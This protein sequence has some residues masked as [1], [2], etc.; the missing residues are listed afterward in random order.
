MGFMSLYH[1][2]TGRVMHAVVWN[3]FQARQLHFPSLPQLC[4]C[5]YRS[6]QVVDWLM[7]IL[8]IMSKRA[9][10]HSPGAKKEPDG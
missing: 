1:V 2:G 4:V 6:Q 9:S 7:I 10:P 5:S 3:T 8:T